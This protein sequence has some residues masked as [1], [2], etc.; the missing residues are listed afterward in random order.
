MQPKKLEEKGTPFNLNHIQSV[1]ELLNLGF[2][3]VCMPQ[4]N[5]GKRLGKLWILP[6]S[7]ALLHLPVANFEGGASGGTI[8]GILN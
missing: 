3:G 7:F 2:L 5:L 4:G 1:F 8:T 6:S